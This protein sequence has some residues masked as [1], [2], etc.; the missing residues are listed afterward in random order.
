MALG[1][2]SFGHSRF[3]TGRCWI[4]KQN[5]MVSA[6]CKTHDHNRAWRPSRH[7]SLRPQLPPRWGRFFGRVRGS[8]LHRNN[9]P[10]R[11]IACRRDAIGAPVWLFFD[12]AFCQSSA[13]L[14]DASYPEEGPEQGSSFVTRSALSHGECDQVARAFIS[15]SPSARAVLAVN[16][17]LAE[18]LSARE[19]ARS[20]EVRCDGPAQA[21]ARQLSLTASPPSPVALAV[22][23]LS[24]LHLRLIDASLTKLRWPLG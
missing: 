22:S 8:P 18:R 17:R 9:G 19:I 14:L 23:L 15:P 1:A 16:R 10:Q 3:K 2:V 5:L 21:E 24:F 12:P 4:L 6:K 20:P 11:L 13:Y 7:F